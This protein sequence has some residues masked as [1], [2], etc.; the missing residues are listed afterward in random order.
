MTYQYGNSGN[1]VAICRV[2]NI[3]EHDISLHIK[4]DI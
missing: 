2:A 3:T 4:L 1:E